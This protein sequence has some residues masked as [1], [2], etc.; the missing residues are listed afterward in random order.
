[1]LNE[2]QLS[3]LL[4]AIGQAQEET[5][6]PIRPSPLNDQALT[7]LNFKASPPVQRALQQG[8]PTILQET[9]LLDYFNSLIESAVLFA[10]SVPYFMSIHETDRIALLKSSVF[11]ML[12]VRH[13]RCYS[14]SCLAKLNDNTESMDLVTLA[15]VASVSRWVIE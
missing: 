2:T 11:E 13:A 10:K 7:N 12:V 14:S 4:K 6:V 3:N 1:M 15:T 9:Q 5:F 8:L